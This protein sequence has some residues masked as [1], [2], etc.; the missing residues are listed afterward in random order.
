MSHKYQN[1]LFNDGLT[2]LNRTSEGLGM[3]IKDAII[4]GAKEINIF[5]GG[6][7]T[8]DAGLG[9]LYALG[10]KF[11]DEDNKPI[12]PLPEIYNSINRIDIKG[13]YLYKDIKINAIVDVNNPFIGPNGASKTFARQKGATNEEINILEEG[14]V[15]LVD[16]IKN[17]YGDDIG[18][19]TSYGAAGGISMALNHFLNAP[20]IKGS[21]YFIELT[22]L[23]NIIKEVDIVITGEGKLDKTSFD[24]KVVS[25]IVDLSKKYDKEVTLIVGKSDLSSEECTRLGI[26][27]LVVINQEEKDIRVLKKNAKKDLYNRTLE[28]F[29]DVTRQ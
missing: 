27:H 20:L 17:Q 10:A 12:Y 4:H 29:K 28:L 2:I 1:T 26:N 5:L 8:N 19:R 23:N 25:S 22:N 21:E 24:G 9:M 18:D 11:Y 13:L 14:L 6:S 16:V 7:C 3:V 15:H